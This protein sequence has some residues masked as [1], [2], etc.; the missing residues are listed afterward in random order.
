MVTHMLPNP[1][2]NH[3]WKADAGGPIILGQQR[4]DQPISRIYPIQRPFGEE[5]VVTIA[6]PM[7]L[8]PRQRPEQETAGDYL[9]ELR[10]VLE[11]L[12]SHGDRER[13]TADYLFIQTESRNP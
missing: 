4:L 8:F 12:E 10:R 13:V 11:S 1:I 7:P 3:F 6:S 5:M 2:D 9:K